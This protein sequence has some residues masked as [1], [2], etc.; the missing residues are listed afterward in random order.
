MGEGI[1]VRSRNFYDSKPGYTKTISHGGGLKD[2][3]Y[4][5]VF[6]HDSDIIRIDIAQH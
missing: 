1:D 2:G 4:A 5:R 6:Y 3:V